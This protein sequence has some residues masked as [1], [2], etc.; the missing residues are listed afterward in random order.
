[1]ITLWKE[2]K[3]IDYGTKKD[4]RLYIRRGWTVKV[5]TNEKEIEN[6][7]AWV[8]CG[9]VWNK[10]NA[11]LRRHVE[12]VLNNAKLEWTERYMRMMN[13]LDYVIKRACRINVVHRPPQKE[14]T[15]KEQLFGVYDDIC[16][17]FS[18]FKRW[19]TPMTAAQY[20]LAN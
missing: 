7:R 16:T 5:L 17:V 15:L 2:G 20:Q 1:M 14:W 9:V 11:P 13:I 6:H 8:K 3:F 10:L 19:M 18:T 4:L 12:F